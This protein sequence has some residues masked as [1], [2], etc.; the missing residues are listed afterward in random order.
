MTALMVEFLWASQKFFYM[1]LDPIRGRRPTRSVALAQRFIELAEQARAA[2]F[3]GIHYFS[4]FTFRDVDE[5][6]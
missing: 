6:R 3:P 4:A 2:V 5:Q 1:I